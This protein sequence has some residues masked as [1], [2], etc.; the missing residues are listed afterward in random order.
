MDQNNSKEETKTPE[1]GLIGVTSS[2]AITSPTKQFSLLVVVIVGAG[3]LLLGVLLGSVAVNHDGPFADKHGQH[4]AKHERSESPRTGEETPKAHDMA[5]MMHDMNARLVGLSGTAFDE[6]FL[7]E[8]II[9]HE[10]AVAMAE[11]ALTNAADPRIKDIAAAIIA[12]QNEEIAAM[13]R[14][15]TAGQ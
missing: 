5:R 12:A 2:P 1:N 15:Q 3:A 4:A 14:W 7:Q 11:L 8:M 9:H 13:Q 6:V 10:G